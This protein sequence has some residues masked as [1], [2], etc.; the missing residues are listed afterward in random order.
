M[1]MNN[2]WKRQHNK[3]ISKYYRFI[4]S[5]ISYVTYVYC[6]FFSRSFF[7]PHRIQE[8]APKIKENALFFRCFLKVLHIK[9]NRFFVLFISL[10]RCIH[11]L[12]RIGMPNRYICMF[13]TFAGSIN[14]ANNGK[15]GI[16]ARIATAQKH[17]LQKR[18]SLHA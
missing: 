16:E 9:L 17:P 15:E 8:I 10:F 7:E 18:N 4:Y 2:Y 14:S 13:P 1:S 5:Q 3:S 6:V 12:E 11:R